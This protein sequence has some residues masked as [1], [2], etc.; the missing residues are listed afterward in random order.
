MEEKQNWLTIAAIVL[1]VA[2]L[3]IFL[4]R[5][6]RQQTDDDLVVTS[7]DQVAEDRANQLIDD[8]NYE[9]P[10]DAQRVNLKDVSGGDAAG[11]A[12]RKEEG[13]AVTQSVLVSLPEPEAGQFYE[14]YLMGASE[15]AEPMYL[16]KLRS[17]KGGWMLDYE[18]S[19]E[20]LELSTIKITRETLDDRKPEETVLEGTF[21]VESEDTSSV[22]SKTE[23]ATPTVEE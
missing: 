12:T 9:I 7:D 1:V 16:G 22:E 23:E 17:V 5:Q 3:G 13:N 8:L 20:S 11:V 18:L 2:G 15:E 21:P 19:Q 4:Y 10:E 14:A 6:S